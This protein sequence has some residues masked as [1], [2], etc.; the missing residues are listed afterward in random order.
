MPASFFKASR[1]GSILLYLP[2]LQ[3]FTSM[4]FPG[5]PNIR[6]A[7]MIGV[8]FFVTVGGWNGI[9]F[10]VNQRGY[11]K[12]CCQGQIKQETQI[13]MHPTSA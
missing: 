4:T 6:L 13:D 7:C 3:E 8:F 9:C 12:P 11:A 5:Y 2:R 1:K 10:C